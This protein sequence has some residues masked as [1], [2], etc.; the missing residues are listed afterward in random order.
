MI[1]C[2]KASSTSE[3]WPESSTTCQAEH[4][5]TLNVFPCEYVNGL[6]IPLFEP[7]ISANISIGLQYGRWCRPFPAGKEG[8][9]GMQPEEDKV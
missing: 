5:L 8:L 2:L 6:T 1:T 9:P 3:C 7:H 4:L